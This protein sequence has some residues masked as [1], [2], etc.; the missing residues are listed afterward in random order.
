MKDSHLCKIGNI[1]SLLFLK[2]GIHLF[3]I[4]SY[5]KDGIGALQS[6]LDLFF[7]V[8][9]GCNTLDTFGFQSLGIGFAWVTRNAS[10]FE[11]AGGLGVAKDGLDD[12]TALIACGAKDN[13]DLLFSHV[14]IDGDFSAWMVA[15]VL[16]LSHLYTRFTRAGKSV[17]VNS[18]ARHDL[19]LSLLFS[20]GGEKRWSEL[21][22]IGDWMHDQSRMLPCVDLKSLLKS[23]LKSLKD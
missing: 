11:L 7:G 23:F 17:A 21:W 15:E 18:V 10:N 6:R 14:G 9:I 12:R 1:A 20:R 16:I 4:V 8:D 5:S 13:E 3:P 2:L 22:L 19:G